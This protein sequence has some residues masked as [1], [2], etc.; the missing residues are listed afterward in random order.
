MNIKLILFLLL[1][2]STTIH[3]R[4]IDADTLIIRFFTWEVVDVPHLITCIN[5]ET[6]VPY[7]EYAVTE[8]SAIN[9]INEK[10]KD[11]HSTQEQDF[12]VACKLLCIKNGA[13]SNIICLNKDYIMIDGKVFSCDRSIVNIIDTLTNKTPPSE[14]KIS[15][16]PE[17]FGAEY[18]KGKEELNKLLSS[19]YNKIKKT[20]Q[21][22]GITKFEILCKASKKGYTKTVQVK[23]YNKNINST[24][25]Q[26]IENYITEWFK[27]KIKWK[28]NNTRMNADWINIYFK[29]PDDL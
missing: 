5:Y 19:Y 12:C 22:K 15:Y 18:C 7:K 16:K 8:T 25:R 4:V 2:I 14:K 26:K 10:F 9:T 24:D 3:A 1:T 27:R 23:L 17:K 6:E 21:I 29:S 28:K 13:I 20:Y 11:L